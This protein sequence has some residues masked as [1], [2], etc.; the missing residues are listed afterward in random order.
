M[1]EESKKLEK[2]RTSSSTLEVKL[3]GSMKEKQLLETTVTTMRAE[4]ANKEKMIEEQE[5]T[6]KIKEERMM[7]QVEELKEEITK[8][9][10]RIQE[11]ES[12]NEVLKQQT[13][14][15]KKKA[16]EI[17]LKFGENQKE[18]TESQKE[19]EKVHELL[20]NATSGIQTI[21]SD[22]QKPNQEAKT[23]VAGTNI[24]PKL[25]QKGS[26]PKETRRQLDKI[27]ITKG[28][29]EILINI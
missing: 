24:S 12:T 17:E 21:K 14:E 26:S 4:L 8:S 11:L 6:F 27:E 5:Y 9:V 28:I 19:L 10:K 3:D 13:E 20:S 15:Q 1:E 7:K 22:V 23:V 2:Y 29:T 18:L 25:S 16:E